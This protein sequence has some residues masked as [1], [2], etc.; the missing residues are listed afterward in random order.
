MLFASFLSGC[1]DATAQQKDE[2]ELGIGSQSGWES[3]L[4]CAGREKRERREGKREW[5]KG[6]D[7]H[8]VPAPLEEGV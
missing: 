8:S 2:A 7:V 6:S 3:V 4:G 5:G 1:L